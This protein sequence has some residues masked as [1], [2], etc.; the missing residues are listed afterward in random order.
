MNQALQEFNVQMQ[1][2]KRTRN[3][4]AIFT[5]IVLFIFA[6]LLA[7]KYQLTTL[8]EAMTYFMI[9]IGGGTYGISEFKARQLRLDFKNKVMP[10][11]IDEKFP[12][13]QYAP[14][15][16]L[17]SSQIMETSLVAGVDRF[18]S[19]DL[20]YGTIEGVEFT[21]GDVR[22]E[23]KKEIL[24]EAGKFVDYTPFFIG[25]IF[26][27][28]F[29]KDLTGLTIVQRKESPAPTQNRSLKP[30]SMESIDFNEQFTVYSTDEHAAYYLV[31]P[32]IIE[33]I[34]TLK[35]QI[36]GSLSFSYCNQTLN[37]GL[38]NFRNTF[39]I[40]LNGPVSQESI[41]VIIRDFQAIQDF[42]RAMKLNHKLFKI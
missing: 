12:G 24:S 13:L 15:K 2:L 37:I 18:S 26:R 42:I 32:D 38:N 21:S 28:Q 27:F 3:Y 31:T 4:G 1:H 23:R 17:T 16:G 30:V 5:L 40:P 9:A 10:K 33:S 29:N 41:D 8:L 20:V 39:E 6:I 19:E 25:R 14:E 22:L 7:V 35:S 11:I 36:D 34:L